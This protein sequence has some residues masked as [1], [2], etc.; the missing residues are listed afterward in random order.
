MVAVAGRAFAFAAGQAACPSAF[1]EPVGAASGDF[2]VGVDERSADSRVGTTSAEVRGSSS[3]GH[4]D[5][6]PSLVDF[7]SAVLDHLAA[8]SVASF[9]GALVASA[10]GPHVDA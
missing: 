7:A 5:L 2:D 10:E 4:L 9:A 1:S 8:A 3:S 6:A